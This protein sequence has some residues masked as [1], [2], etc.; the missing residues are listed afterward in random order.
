MDAGQGPIE[1][2]FL[3]LELIVSWLLAVSYTA[4][5]FMH[6]ISTTSREFVAIRGCTIVHMQPQILHRSNAIPT[7]YMHHISVLQRWVEQKSY[8]A[9]SDV[10]IM[11][12]STQ[13]ICVCY[14]RR[15]VLTAVRCASLSD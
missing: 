1:G 14:S 5:H 11:R 8:Q 4:L 9:H 10:N 7:P 15:A 3:A 6:I 12:A 2:I 13:F